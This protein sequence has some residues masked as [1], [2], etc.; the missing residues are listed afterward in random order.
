MCGDSMRSISEETF[1][2]FQE[3]FGFYVSDLLD[4]P[5]VG[6]E[7]N[8]SRLRKVSEELELDFDTLVEQLG[9]DFEIER[10]QTLEKV[11]TEMVVR[12]ND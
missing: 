5:F 2:W 12:K 11:Q 8:F 4:D 1:A 7:L 6:E 10:F 9:T 3:A